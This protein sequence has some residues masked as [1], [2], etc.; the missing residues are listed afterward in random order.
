HVRL[1]RIP[2][3]RSPDR[4]ADVTGDATTHAKPVIDLLVGRGPSEHHAGHPVATS[5][6]SLLG[7]GLAVLPAV[8]ALD[9]PDVRL[10]PG[11]L[12]LGNRVPHEPGTHLDIVL[13]LIASYRL[14]LSRLGRNEQLEQELPPPLVQPVGQALQTL[15]LASVQLRIAPWV[16][17]DEHLREGRIELLDVRAEVLPV[18]E[19]ELILPT[20]LDRHRE[21]HP[22]RLGLARDVGSEL[23]VDESPG[24]FT[25]HALVERVQQSLEDHRLGVGDACRLLGGGLT[26]HPEELLLERPTVIERQDVERLV[27]SEIHPASF[28]TRARTGGWAPSSEPRR[29][30]PPVR[31]ARRTRESPRRTRSAAERQGSAS[32]PSPGPPPPPAPWCTDRRRCRPS[33]RPRA[34][35]RARERDP[36]RPSDSRRPHRARARSRPS[37]W[38]S[39][40][41][42]AGA[43]PRCTRARPCTSLRRPRPSPPAPRP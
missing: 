5:G 18:L 17:A 3:D 34:R 43:R 42:P 12:Q 13:G 32:S 15:G 41:P 10:D 4:E 6:A 39:G 30:R 20:L 24:R 23:L 28:L 7:D 25:R 11:L 19:V 8:D 22:V 1:E 40:G 35:R 16:V 37:C 21:R 2:P 26:G 9:L 14:E 29:V 31:I 33:P 27:V 36:C 38:P